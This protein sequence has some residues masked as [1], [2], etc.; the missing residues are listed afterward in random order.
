M[1]FYCV[2]CERYLDDDEVKY[3]SESRGE[4]WGMPAYETMMYCGYCGGDII[5]EDDDDFP[6]EEEDE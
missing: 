6:E 4:F 3:V 1:R 2:D 5:S